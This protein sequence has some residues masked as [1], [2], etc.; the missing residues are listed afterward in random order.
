M[1]ANITPPHKVYLFKLQSLTQLKLTKYSFEV[2]EIMGNQPFFI[3]NKYDGERVQ[4][5]KDGDSYRYFS[6]K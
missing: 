3:E 4:L 6:R 2:P 1:L 5:H